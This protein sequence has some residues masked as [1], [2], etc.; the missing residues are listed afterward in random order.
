MTQ[1]TARLREVEDTPDL[2]PSPSLEKKLQDANKAVAGNVPLIADAPNTVF[3]L[4]RGYYNG[5]K[6]ETE[7]EVRE[8]TGSDEESL[9]RFKDPADFFNGIVVYGTARIGSIDLDG[10]PFAD[11]SSALAS[12][13]IG[14]REQLFVQIASATYGDEKHITHRCPFCTTEADTTIILS[15]DFK[16]ADAEP[17]QMTYSLMTRKGHSLEFRLATGADQMAMFARKGASGAEQNTIM[18]S[19]CLLK[20]DGEPVVDPLGVARS[21][22][23]GDRRKMLDIMID[24]QPSPDFTL[25]VDCVSCGEEMSLPLSWQD[26]FR[27]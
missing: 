5:T 21:L 2:D 26:I 17:L 6:W 10:Q 15:E 4:P 12:L 20:I 14:E 24:T 11:R 13:L 25:K 16:P 19:E 7:V 18:I 3:Q 8:L 1:A 23:I 27:D 9:A 22:S